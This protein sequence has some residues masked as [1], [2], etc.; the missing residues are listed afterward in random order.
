V[1]KCK[2][3]E[4]FYEELEQYDVQYAHDLNMAIYSGLE[5]VENLGVFEVSVKPVLTISFYAYLMP[6]YET[7][8]SKFYLLWIKMLDELLR[9]FLC[10]FR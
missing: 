10:S 2:K 1:T 6:P 7:Y 5:D 8:A 4:E 3:Y 9:Y